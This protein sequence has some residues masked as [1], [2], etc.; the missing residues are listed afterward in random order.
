MKILFKSIIISAILVVAFFWM[1][2]MA[3]SHNIKTEMKLT[4]L[5]IILFLLVILSYDRIFKNKWCGS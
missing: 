1:C 5:I 4:P 3:S 2:A